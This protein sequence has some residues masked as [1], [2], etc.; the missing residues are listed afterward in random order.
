MTDMFTQAK[1]IMIPMY[2]SLVAG[3]LFLAVVI[4]V[5]A[6]NVQTGGEFLAS[7]I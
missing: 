5:C 1:L 6:L 4:I 3:T 2:P 7:W